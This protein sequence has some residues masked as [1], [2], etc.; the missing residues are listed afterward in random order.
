MN[1]QDTQNLHPCA[2][3]QV[4][5]ICD[6]KVDRLLARIIELM[7]R[8]RR[9]HAKRAQARAYAK[10]SPRL[11]RDIGLDDPQV[12]MSRYDRNFNVEAE[13]REMRPNGNLNL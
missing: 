7:A 1:A 6:S 8:V 10:L 9:Y 3:S 4:L 13:L 5:D 11:L 2:Q 12:Q